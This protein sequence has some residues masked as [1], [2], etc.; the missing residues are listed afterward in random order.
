MNQNQKDMVLG[1]SGEDKVLNFLNETNECEFK[2]YPNKWATFDFYSDDDHI[3]ELK[4]RRNSYSK[5]DTTM[6]GVNKLS[7]ALS[8]NTKK[9]VFLFLFTDGLYKWDLNRGQ[10]YIK[11]GGRQDRGIDERKTYAFINIDNLTLLTDEITSL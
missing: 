10:Y 2:Q 6:I 9:Y 3:V 7:K 4:S 8:D 1:L 5:Y 11:Y